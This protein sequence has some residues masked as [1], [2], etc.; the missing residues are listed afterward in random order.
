VAGAG[1]HLG[2][3]PADLPCTGRRRAAGAEPPSARS[4]PAWSS[5]PAPPPCGGR[6]GHE[7]NRR[8][9]GHLG[10]RDDL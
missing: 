6:L 7:E 8:G 2:W 5:F 4:C 10:R 3:S 9:R 1:G